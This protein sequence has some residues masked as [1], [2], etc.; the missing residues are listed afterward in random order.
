M[1]ADVELWLCTSSHFSSSSSSSSFSST[2]PISAGGARSAQGGNMTARNATWQ[3][4]PDNPDKV[5]MLH[6]MALVSA[7]PYFKTRCW[8]DG[9]EG[10]LQYA[11]AAPAPEVEPVETGKRKR[12]EAPPLLLLVE[13]VEEEE[14]P[15]MEAVL[16]HCYTEELCDVG[17][18]ESELSVALLVQMLVLSNRCAKSSSI[19]SV[20]L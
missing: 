14:L 4:P 15:A 8:T 6:S 17:G 13:H 1:N 2:A 5:F 18:D 7:S 12:A 9:A 16:R 19:K 20:L 3:K 10:R 11:H